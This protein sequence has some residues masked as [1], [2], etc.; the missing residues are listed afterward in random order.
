MTQ[1]R[2][3]LTTLLVCLLASPESLLSE[4][5]TADQGPHQYPAF[6]ALLQNPGYIQFIAFKR[7]GKDYSVN[8]KKFP[9]PFVSFE[10]SVQSNTYYIRQTVDLFHPDD[11]GALG[12][13]IGNSLHHSWICQP[14]SITKLALGADSDTNSP[15]RDTTFG[16]LRWDLRSVLALG[17]ENLSTETIRWT[18]ETQFIAQGPRGD[19]TGTIDSGDGVARPGSVSL[20][21]P[22]RP[23]I[24][25]RVSYHYLDDGQRP[26]WLPKLVI[27]AVTNAPARMFV[28]YTNEITACRFGLTNPGP[29]GFTAEMFQ[30]HAGPDV[31][32]TELWTKNGVDYASRDGRVLRVGE[33]I[34]A[35]VYADQQRAATIRRLLRTWVL[36]GAAI[37]AAVGL[38]ALTVWWIRQKKRR[39]LPGPP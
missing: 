25:T 18:N 17:M 13:A 37:S 28:S 34:G 22:S 8:E 26:S 32:P 39:P 1:H 21:Y 7:D 35:Q 33:G 10:A 11:T 20:R 29:Q 30:D 9:K 2:I 38:L 16:V 24:Q 4:G 3:L 12:P 15:P 19:V 27:I 6:K 23:E 36:P 5:L 14:G 31:L